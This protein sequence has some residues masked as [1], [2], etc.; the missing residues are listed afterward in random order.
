MAA[1]F[2]VLYLLASVRG[3]V[4]GLCLNLRAPE[5]A[6]AHEGEVCVLSDTASCCA[7][8]EAGEEEGPD[9]TPA[10]PKSCPMCRLALG[11][12][13]PPDYIHFEPLTPLVFRPAFG[14]PLEAATQ[15]IDSARS[16]RGPPRTVAA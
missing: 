11:L 8:V 1:F 6:A 3:L 2:V 13:E 14:A 9:S 7:S 10:A 16:G 4:P 12:T 15:Q 5:D